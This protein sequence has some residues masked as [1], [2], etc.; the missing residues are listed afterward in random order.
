LF[1]L[2]SDRLVGFRLST[3]AMFLVLCRLRKAFRQREPQ[4]GGEQA[5]PSQPQ[6]RRHHVNRWPFHS[7]FLLDWW[8]E[9]FGVESIRTAYGVNRRLVLLGYHVSPVNE[10]C[11]ENSVEPTSGNEGK[12]G[13]SGPAS[14]VFHIRRVNMRSG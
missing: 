3:A 6:S 5:L 7:L 14:G 10:K 1:E 2:E 12:A 9:S 13:R 4:R 11:V 8:F